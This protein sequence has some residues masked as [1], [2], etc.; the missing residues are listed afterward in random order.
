MKKFKLEK[1]WT[2]EEALNLALDEINNGRLEYGEKF[3]INTVNLMV[4]DL[5]GIPTLARK[6]K[7]AVN[8]SPVFV[9]DSMSGKMKGIIAMGSNCKL[10]KYCQDR[11]NCA[12]PC[13]I[14]KY[15]FAALTL[16]AYAGTDRLTAHNTAILSNG[17]IPDDL[18]PLF[19]GEGRDIRFEP[20]GDLSSIFQ[21]ANYMHIAAINPG[22][23]FTLWTKNA[24]IVADAFR[25]IEGLE[26]PSNMMII[27]SSCMINNPGRK[28]YDFIDKV[29]HVMTAAYALKHEIKFNCCGE[30]PE[31]KR[32]CAS[33]RRC[34]DR[35]NQDVDIYELLRADDD[36]TAAI[37]EMTL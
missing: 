3:K 26:K 22:H 8:Y 17:I 36:I 6:S 20:F 29:F 9:H 1:N 12:D 10:N 14:C 13:C 31:E 37:N 18:L 2:Y 34:Y 15:C 7:F 16:K 4:V 30:N 25:L 23:N 19:K 33:C 24:W 27:E 32:H 28:S 21:V 11:I 35:S 5:F